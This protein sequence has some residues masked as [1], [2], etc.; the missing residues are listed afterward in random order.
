MPAPVL[1]SDLFLQWEQCGYKTE[2]VA[3]AV[4]PNTHLWVGMSTISSLQKSAHICQGF[5][6][7]VTLE[8]NMC[9][10]AFPSTPHHPEPLPSPSLQSHPESCC[11]LSKAGSLQPLHLSFLVSIGAF[12]VG[13]ALDLK[14][15]PQLLGTK[16]GLE[17]WVKSDFPFVCSVLLVSACFHPVFLL[18]CIF[19]FVSTLVVYFFIYLLIILYIINSLCFNLCH[20]NGAQQLHTL[21][22]LPE[23][24]TLT[25]ITHMEAHNH[26]SLQSQGTHG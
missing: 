18:C 20:Q 19:G 13:A 14:D 17:T 9:V 5:P 4:S 12:H 25:L 16:H 23:A 2:N 26:L 24:P 7:P 3:W 6:L 21:A 8:V 1:Y 22:A 11:H 10:K 15:T